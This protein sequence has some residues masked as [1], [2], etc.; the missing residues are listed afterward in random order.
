MLLAYKVSGEKALSLIEGGE[1]GEL[2]VTL[3]EGRNQLRKSHFLPEKSGAQGDLYEWRQEPT[4]GPHPVESG[5][6]ERRC[7]R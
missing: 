4:E 5:S 1:E 3:Q 6:T 7:V 2:S